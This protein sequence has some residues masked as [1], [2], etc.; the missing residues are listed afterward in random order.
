[1]DENKI[2]ELKEAIKL[3]LT[4]IQ[5]LDEFLDAHGLFYKD[6]ESLFDYAIK[7]SQELAWLKKHREDNYGIA[8]A[9]GV[10]KK[11]TLDQEKAQLTVEIRSMKD[12]LAV[13][14]LVGQDICMELFPELMPLPL[15]YSD[16]QAKLV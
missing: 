13:Q 3:E 8:Q 5:N 12:L 7:Q 9:R 14:P 2:Y 16:E 15:E 6:W 10:I 4:H 1:M 11:I